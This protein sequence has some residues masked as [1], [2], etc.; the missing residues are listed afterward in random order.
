M[1]SSRFWVLG[2]VTV[3][4]LAALFASGVRLFMPPQWGAPVPWLRTFSYNLAHFALWAALAPLLWRLARALPL[5]RWRWVVPVQLAVSCAIACSQLVL[6]ELALVPLLPADDPV[7]PA[8]ADAIRFSLAINF[9]AAVMTYWAITGAAYALL[10]HRRAVAATQLAADARFR[11]LESHVAPHF[12]FNALNSVAALVELDPP[13]ATR[14]IARLGDLLRQSLATRERPTLTLD[15]ELAVV[16]RYLDIEQW[17]FADRLVVEI[18]ANAAARRCEV[19]AFLLQ[20]LVENAIRHGLQPSVEPV[21][22]AVRARVDEQRLALEVSDDAAASA[23]PP[24]HGFG[25]ERTRA[26]LAQS[27]GAAHAFRAGPGERGF[28]VEI[29]IPAVAP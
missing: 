16:A 14:L 12:L 1:K 15:Q 27:Y 28:R 2:L 10:F 13:E 26:R 7:R 3:V 11:T 9:Q 24:G 29:E 6:A 17:R 22:I 18:D 19:P 25:L 4:A 5:Q 20:P 8:L 21:T 23:A